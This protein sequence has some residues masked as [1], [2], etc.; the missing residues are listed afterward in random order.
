MLTEKGQKTVKA[1]RNVAIF[2]A[3]L[4]GSY[5]GYK[6]WGD[7]SPDGKLPFS[8]KS[9]KP[10]LVVAYNTFT[11]V[12]G[13]VLMNGGMDPNENSEMY[14]KYGVKLQIKQMDAVKDTRAGL[15]SGDIDLAYCTVDALS[16]EMGSGSEL[17]ADNVNVIMQV[18][19]SHGADAV[20]VRK[21][22]TKVEDL[23]GKK[24]AYAVGTASNTLL[25]NVLESSGLKTS[26][27]DN[28]KVG[29][30]VEAANAFKNNQCDAAVVWA[31]DDEDCVAALNGS[32]VLVSTAVASQIISDGL[33]VKQS[34]LKSKHDK[35]VSLVKAWL[36]GNARLNNDAAAKKEANTLFAKG[37]K[38]PEDIASKSADKV[39]FSTLGD[40]VNFFGLNSTYTGM[41]SERMYGRMAIKYT[42]IGLTKSPAPWRNISDPSVIQE[43]MQDQNFAS[44]GKQAAAKSE[45]FKPATEEMKTQSSQSSKVISL[46]FATNS[47]RL[48][49]D[50]KALVDREINELAQGFAGAYIRV[51]GNTDNVGNAVANDKLSLNRAQ[52]VVNYLI[53]EHKFD[54]NKF[55]I[56]GNGSRKPVTGCEANQDEGCK[57]RNRRTEFQFIWKSE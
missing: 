22:I 45:G 25:L 18:N 38:F 3:V 51:E 37:F 20:V 6:Y 57:A 40:N 26:D 28:Y 21:G 49:D 54:V 48:N 23:K 36:Q 9:G 12:E 17:I 8:D 35:I 44:D 52:A 13:L 11:G 16:V 55:I 27:I 14:K 46:E 34:V 2:A 10:D 29:D 41:T 31:P 50:S 24:V 32:K 4:G 5:L 33:L 56:V 39:Y 43:I 47:A 1:I 30:G 15:H 19:Q 42:E 7:S 53:S